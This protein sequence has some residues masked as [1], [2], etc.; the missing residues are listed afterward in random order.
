MYL[1]SFYYCWSLILKNLFYLP[2]DIALFLFL[3]IFLIYFLLSF[4]YSCP[5]FLPIPPP[6]PG[7]I[8]LTPQHPPPPWFCSCVLYMSFC[9]PL[10]PLSPPHYPLDLVRLLLTS[11]SLVIFCF[12]FPSIYYVPVKGE[13]IWHLSLT[14]QLISLSIIRCSSI[15][16]VAKGISSFALS[17]V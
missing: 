1:A 6:D 5:P 2:L 4:N 9:N 17:A 8:H 11:M 13:I 10:S 12:L 3:W 15:H 7:Q 16:A 14:A